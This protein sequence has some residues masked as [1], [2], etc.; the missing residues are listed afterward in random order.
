MTI[1]FAFETTMDVLPII[2]DNTNI[3]EEEY[4]TIFTIS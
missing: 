1:L 2:S 3:L 4:L